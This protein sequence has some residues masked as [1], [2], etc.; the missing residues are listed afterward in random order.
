MV[1]KDLDVIDGIAGL[2]AGERLNALARAF[3]RMLE[4]DNA[5]PESDSASGTT[6]ASGATPQ[7]VAPTAVASSQTAGEADVDWTHKL[8]D[9]SADRLAELL[10]EN[11]AAALSG[12]QSDRLAQAVEASV[13]PAV[14][15]VWTAALTA[16]GLA[17]GVWSGGPKREFERL[18]VLG[19]L[20]RWGEARSVA[21]ALVGRLLEH[22]GALGGV[23]TSDVAL[24]FPDLAR[25][26]ATPAGGVAPAGP[27]RIVFVG[28]NEIQARYDAS[29][30]MEL[31]E[32]YG[33][34][35]SVEWVHPGWSANWASQAEKAE[36][37]LISADA[38][39][40]MKLVRTNLGAEMR[41]VADTADV[42]W[43][44]CT[45]HGRASILGALEKAVAVVDAGTRDAPEVFT[46]AA[47]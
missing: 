16:D 31:D 32:R 44:A 1:A 27:V 12:G 5:K 23:S 43:I 21:Q 28:G 20:D 7:T 46:G 19:R 17:R 11:E 45:G 22:G 18:R 25:A 24:Y 13:D 4:A 26:V 38:L 34:R 14:D 36:A 8:T 6:S 39:V 35:V 41:R 37:A 15:E 9:L 42:P 10:A 2:L 47:R 29:I 40:L 3:A 30:E 33:G